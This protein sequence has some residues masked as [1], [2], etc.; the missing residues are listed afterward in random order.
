[1]ASAVA[2]AVFL[3][4]RDA[5]DPPRRVEVEEVDPWTA[6][7]SSVRVRFHWHPVPWESVAEVLW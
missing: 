1:V 5:I 3:G 4:V 2:A 7:G 6:G